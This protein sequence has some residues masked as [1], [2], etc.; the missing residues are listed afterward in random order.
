[1]QAGSA[2]RGRAGGSRLAG[3]AGVTHGLGVPG[4]LRAAGGVGS[5]QAL[6]RFGV[7]SV[8]SALM[9]AEGDGS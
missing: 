9:V 2:G 4:L 1:V 6:L 7:R 3:V 5:A 8:C